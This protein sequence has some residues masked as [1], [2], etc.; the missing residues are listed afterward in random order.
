[1]IQRRLRKLIKLEV[2]THSGDKDVLEVEEYSAT[3]LNEKM[4]DNETHSILIG[5]N[6]YSRIDLRN[7]KVIK[8]NAE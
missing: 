7:V 6:N 4:N 1:M 3:E 2:T 8:E 5:E